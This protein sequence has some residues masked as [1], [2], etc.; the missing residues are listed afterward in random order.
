MWAKSS[1][2]SLKPQFE[3]WSIAILVNCNFPVR[4]CTHASKRCCKDASKQ[5]R[6]PAGPEFIMEVFATPDP[7]EEKLGDAVELVLGLFDIWD[8]VPQCI[9]LNFDGPEIINQMR[10][11]VEDSLL[12][13][14]TISSVRVGSLNRKMNRRS[15]GIKETIPSVIEGVEKSKM[16]SRHF[17]ISS[18]MSWV[19]KKMIPTKS[20]RKKKRKKKMSKW[21][22]APRMRKWRRRRKTKRRNRMT[23]RWM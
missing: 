15:K 11:G 2:V 8:S 1:W 6:T 23:I 17:L 18:M 14:C 3:G 4:F 12:H 16:T 5:S 19:K 10:R 21:S 20:R 22:S 9:P 7:K 13:F